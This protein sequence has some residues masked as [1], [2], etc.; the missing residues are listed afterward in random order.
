LTYMQCD[1]GQAEMRHNK[2]ALKDNKEISMDDQI[3][4]QE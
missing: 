2:K 3:H 1:Y 4:M